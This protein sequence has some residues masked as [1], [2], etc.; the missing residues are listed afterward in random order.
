MKKFK[1]TENEFFVCEECNAIFKTQRLLIFHLKKH[2]KRQYFDKYL[3]D[4]EEGLCKTCK[5]PTSFISV[6]NGYRKWCCKKCYNLDTYGVEYYYQS[7]DFKK[8]RK[9]T[10]LIKYGMEEPL[11]SE[12]IKEKG[13]QTCLKNYG[14]EHIL[15]SNNFKENCMINKYGIRNAM[16]NI[17]MFN[18]MQNTSKLKFQYKNTNIWYQGSYELDFLEKYYNKYLNIQRGPTIKY[19]FKN[20]EKIYYPDFYIPSLN[21]VI[22]VKSKYWYNINKQSVKLKENACIK[23]NYLYVLIVDKNYN[24]FEDFLSSIL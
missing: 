15:Q 9:E 10:C 16:H 5:I 24:Y 7:N 1:K 17:D 13:K 11:R 4:N 23:N 21:L 8:R 18:K 19:K 14:V 12:Y 3:K 6:S 20:K 2:G 22:E